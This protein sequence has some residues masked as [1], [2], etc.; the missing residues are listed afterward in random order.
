[1]KR[2]ARNHSSILLI[3]LRTQKKTDSR[4]EKSPSQLLSP[5]RKTPIEKESSFTSNQLYWPDRCICSSR[6]NE[7]RRLSRYS[8]WERGGIFP[9][10]QNQVDIQSHSPQQRKRDTQSAKTRTW[11]SPR[12]LLGFHHPSFL[13]AVRP[14][15][16]C[17][18]LS[19]VFEDALRRSS[20]AS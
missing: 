13:L 14:P 15:L 10:Q 6:P 11:K 4:Q 5:V 9:I 7:H 2:V 1:M 20:Q 8:C 3:D 16:V 18:F 19:L 17:V 12:S